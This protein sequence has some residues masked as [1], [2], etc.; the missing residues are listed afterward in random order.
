[1]PKT[2]KKPAAPTKPRGRPG[3]KP[4]DPELVKRALELAAR[5]SPEEAAEQLE[6]ENP[7]P[8]GVRENP[9]APSSRQIRAWQKG[10]SGQAAVAAEVAGTSPTAKGAPA[11]PVVVEEPP[12]DLSPQQRRLWYV[13]RQIARV[14]EALAVAEQP[15]INLQRVGS[16]NEQLRKWLEV[17]AE[18]QPAPKEDPHAERRQW[19]QDAAA[20]IAKIKSGIARERTNGASP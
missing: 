11:S 12:A 5:T 9:L 20:V 1:M 19:E 7:R 3:R 6:R 18:L 14:R 13:E 10:E 15:P 17:H 2:T 16:L 4:R 8:P